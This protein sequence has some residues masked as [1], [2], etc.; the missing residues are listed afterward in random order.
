MIDTV[1]GGNRMVDE[2]LEG[3][4]GPKVSH[5]EEKVFSDGLYDPWQ[6]SRQSAVKRLF[7]RWE[8]PFLLI[9]T[10]LIILIVIFLLFIP[11]GSGDTTRKFAHLEEK[12]G[13]IETQLNALEMKI[14]P[15]EEKLGKLEHKIGTSSSTGDIAARLDAQAASIERLTDR[16]ANI[17]SSIAQR[18]DH[19]VK[20]VERSGK[21]KPIAEKK[22][23]PTPKP[24]AASVKPNNSTPKAPA[25]PQ[26]AAT[27]AEKPNNTAVAQHKTTQHVVRPG[28]TLY[29]ISKQ[30]KISVDALRQLNKLPENATISTGQKL[31]VPAEG[32]N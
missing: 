3:L 24:A 16:L 23:E 6:R 10:S 21:G 12:I 19:A 5:D 4:A 31:T 27:P 9:G 2:E 22:A 29:R 7:N 26:K 11:R 17:D 15:V 25:P 18:V 20:G 28:E 32:G 13:A 14:A 30:Y 8:T 1:K